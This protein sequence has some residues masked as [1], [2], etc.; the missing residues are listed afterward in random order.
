M[1][2]HDESARPAEGTPAHPRQGQ[3]QVQLVRLFDPSRGKCATAQTDPTSG[4]K[5]RHQAGEFSV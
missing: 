5:P 1:R 4:I 2:L 3:V